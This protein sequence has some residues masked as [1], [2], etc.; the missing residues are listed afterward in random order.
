MER[1]GLMAYETTF[2]ADVR[3]ACVALLEAYKAAAGVRL[4]VY[5]GRPASIM[6]P[7]AFVDRISEGITYPAYTYPTR[8]PRAEI[9]VLHGLFD[10]GE[11][12]DQA[13]AFADGFLEWAVANIGEAGANTTV[14]VV[15]IED[16]ATYVPDWLKPELQR[17]YFSTRITLE[18]FAGG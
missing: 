18:G 7:T 15:E 11:A 2:R 9:V 8:T 12:V 13:D 4:Q 17:T 1:G 5:R 16:D 3:A 14:S 6:P 10:S